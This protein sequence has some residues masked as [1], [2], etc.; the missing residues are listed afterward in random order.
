MSGHQ[1]EAEHRLEELQRDIDE[2]RH[3][4]AEEEGTTTDEPRFI[5][6]GEVDGPVDDTIVPPG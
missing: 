1:E 2:Q 3:E 6:S 4:L 5:D